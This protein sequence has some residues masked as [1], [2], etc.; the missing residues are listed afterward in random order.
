MQNEYIMTPNSGEVMNILCCFPGNNKLQ[1]TIWNAYKMIFS[2]FI[3][4][5]LSIIAPDN[6]FE[7]LVTVQTL[8]KHRLVNFKCF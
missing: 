4:V 6:W 3:F 7:D 8:Y 5:C 1:N 2:L